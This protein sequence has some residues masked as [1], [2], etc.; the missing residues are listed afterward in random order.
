MIGGTAAGSI[1][2]AFGKKSDLRGPETCLR[3][4]G[5]LAIIEISQMVTR[6]GHR[7]QENNAGAA[8]VAPLR[9]PPAAAAE[10][11]AGARVRS[12]H[13]RRAQHLQD[14]WYV[15]KHSQEAEG[16]PYPFT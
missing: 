10:G 3:I 1:F 8:D 16:I 14:V 5:S 11:G 2:V 15:W 6:R 4:S 13:L 7:Q 12:R 9:L